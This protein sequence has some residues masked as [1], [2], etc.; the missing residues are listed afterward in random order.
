MCVF[1]CLHL[2]TGLWECE[3]ARAWVAL[4]ICASVK[5]SVLINR[6]AVTHQPPAGLTW[7]W[8]VTSPFTSFYRMWYTKWSGWTRTPMLSNVC[9]HADLSHIHTHTH[10]YIYSIPFS[11]SPCVCVCVCVCVCLCVCVCVCVCVHVCISWPV[12]RSTPRRVHNLALF[13]KFWLYWLNHSWVMSTGTPSDCLIRTCSRLCLS[14]C[15]FCVFAVLCVSTCVCVCMCL[16][17]RLWPFISLC[18]CF[19]LWLL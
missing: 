4:R 11:L 9:K 16:S 8:T 12:F 19:C 5:C 1:V 17:V 18:L 7:T 15:L 14:A 13:I 2:C 3:R 10:T 6:P